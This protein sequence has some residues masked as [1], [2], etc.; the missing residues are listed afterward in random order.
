MEHLT[1][2]RNTAVFHAA[3]RRQPIDIEALLVWTFARQRAHRV[4][5]RSMATLRDTLAGRT[6]DSIIRVQRLAEVGTRVDGGG[7]PADHLHPDAETV[8]TLATDEL[9]IRCAE[10]YT[11]PDWLPGAVP[12][13]VPVLDA[14]GRPL[15]EYEPW[16]HNRNYGWCRVVWPVTAQQIDAARARYTHWHAELVRL[17]RHRGVQRLLAWRVTGP[18]IPAAPWRGRKAA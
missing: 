7:P 3:D 4:V 11:R 5:A 14:R 13:A 16:D 18:Q 17:A 15:R 1:E 2:H 8:A 10:T 6:V 9:V 12:R